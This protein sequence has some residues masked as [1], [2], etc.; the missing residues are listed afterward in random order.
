MAGVL[1]EFSDQDVYAAD[2]FDYG[3]GAVR[4]FLD[5]GEHPPVDW[6]IMN[7]PYKAAAKFI[8]TALEHPAAKART[9]VAALVRLGFLE[10]GRRQP[11]F[12]RY[13]PHVVAICVDRPAML[14]GRWVPGATTKMP[15]C[16]IV[17]LQDGGNLDW[18]L[19]PRFSHRPVLSWIPAGSKILHTMPQD[20]A[21]FMACQEIPLLEV[22]S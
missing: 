3:Y 9:G 14:K 17:W 4:D 16:W 1:Q 13:P 6:W 10:A 7:P 15:Y 8:M 22:A 2:V 21:R 12:I 18:H 11:L 5:E 20:V 19:L